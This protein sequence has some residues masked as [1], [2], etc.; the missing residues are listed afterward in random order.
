MTS[1]TLFEDRPRRTSPFWA[2]F[3]LGVWLFWGTCS[4]AWAVDANSSIF[5]SGSVAA[6]SKTVSQPAS[7]SNAPLALPEET[8]Q[9]G[10]GFLVYLRILAALALTLGLVVLCVWGL[11]VLWGKQG[12]DRKTVGERP[13]KILASTHLAPRK[14]V[15]LVEVGKRILVVGSG[16]DE[17]TNLGVIQDPEEVEMVRQAARS[18]SGFTDI[19]K[20]AWSRQET[21]K[22]R[23]E[24]SRLA[25]EGREAIGGW[26]DKLKSLSKQSKSGPGTG[27]G[28]E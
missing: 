4:F 17:L 16:R 19:F 5:Q 9:E 3:A 23:E 12:W 15:H 11:K 1:H 6:G 2:F 28:G 27:G 7:S 14:Q 26:V 18:D 8:P 10:P 24:A 20:K 21:G 22:I 25:G 13:L